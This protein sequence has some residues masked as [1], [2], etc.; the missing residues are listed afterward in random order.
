MKMLNIKTFFYIIYIF[1][2]KI[3][4]V[5]F[6]LNVSYSHSAGKAR[7]RALTVKLKPMSSL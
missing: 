5:A 6:M 1:A 2:L 4:R 7:G 3:V